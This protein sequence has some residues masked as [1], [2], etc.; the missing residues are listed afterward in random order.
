MI[1]AGSKFGLAIVIAITALAVAGA[2]WLR[3]SSSL[4][5]VVALVLRQ[6]AAQPLAAAPANQR[7]GRATMA[8][9]LLT[10]APE[11]STQGLDHRALYWLMQ[12]GSRGARI[13]TLINPAQSAAAQMTFARP[14]SDLTDCVYRQNGA[15]L[16]D[17]D[18]RALAIE[19]ITTFVRLVNDAAKADAA[20][21]E[22]PEPGQYRRELQYDSDA[23]R[24]LKDRVL[25]TLRIRVQE[26]RLVAG[27]FDFFLPAE[28]LDVLRRT[29]TSED[30]CARG[31]S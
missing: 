17:P 14:W 15:A 30:R 11:G 4:H 21:L 19:T 13:G 23:A 22:R 9:L 26:G 24:A 1:R 5:A 31:R 27:D 29:P 16:C 12:T 18:N 28:I 3:T 20:A 2:D 7:M 10:C 25:A 8:P 6:P